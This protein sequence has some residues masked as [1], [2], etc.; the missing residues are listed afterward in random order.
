MGIARSL[1]RRLESL[2]EGAPGRVFSGRIHPAEMA[3]RIAREADLGSFQHETGTATAN[4]FVLTV[5]PKDMRSDPTELQASLEAILGEH[6]AE[7]GLRLEGPPSVAIEASEAVSK[8]QF[9]TQLEVVPG[10]LAPWAQLRSDTTGSYDIC[11]N[12]A[13]VGRSDDVDVIIPLDDVSR[14]HALIWREGGDVFIRDLGS[15]N[16]TRI[17][18]SL[19]ESDAV[20]LDQPS[21]V[22]FASNRYR[23]VP[24]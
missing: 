3:T 20:R 1:E 8:G 18:G 22:A 2:F 6:A 21:V 5:N 14:R 7:A 24:A 4:E 9:T 19:L 15:S 16:G 23:L 11:H 10:Q 17:D 12:R 13:L